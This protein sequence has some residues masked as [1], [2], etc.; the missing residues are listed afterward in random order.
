M[1]LT[2][3]QLSKQINKDMK[4]ITKAVKYGVKNGANKGKNLMKSVT[5]VDQG[6]MKKSWNVI[7]E[8]NKIT[9]NNDA[10]HAGIVE[11]GARPHSVNQEGFEAIKAWC[12]RKLP[13]ASEKEINS[14]TYAIINKIKNQGQEGTFIVR[15]N[16]DTLVSLVFDEIKSE[17][18]KLK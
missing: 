13:G 15:D 10:P 16:L 14:F 3:G 11:Y 6:L 8:D 2:L 7:E 9:I 17:L 4:A 1:K 12:S 18:D 5:P